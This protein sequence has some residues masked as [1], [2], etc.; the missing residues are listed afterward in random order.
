MTYARA[1][2][3]DQV[4]SGAGL[5][6]QGAALAEAALSGIHR[7]VAHSRDLAAAG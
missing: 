1:S 3:D 7:A 4:D 5:V 2:T 6:A